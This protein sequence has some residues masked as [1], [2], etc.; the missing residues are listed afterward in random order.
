MLVYVLV[1]TRKNFRCLHGGDRDAL[2]SFNTFVPKYLPPDIAA[3]A[4]LG[5]FHGN[6]PIKKLDCFEF[7]VYDEFGDE[8]HPAEGLNWYDM[9]EKHKAFL[10]A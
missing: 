7:R 10:L 1:T 3:A 4:A 2:G 6:V 5:A 8:M 9:A